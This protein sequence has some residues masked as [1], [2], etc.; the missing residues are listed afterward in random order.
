MS[1]LHGLQ[2]GERKVAVAT[3]EHSEFCLTGKPPFDTDFASTAITPEQ[4]E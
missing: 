1:A 2:A 3:D 4:G